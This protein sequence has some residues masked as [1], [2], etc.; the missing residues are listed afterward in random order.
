MLKKLNGIFAFAIYDG[1]RQAHLFLARDGIGVK[2]LYYAE[3]MSGFLF[4]SEIKALLV[5]NE[6]K[7]EID[8]TAIHYYLAYLWCPGQ[9]TALQA[10]KK[11]Q[12]GEAMIIRDGRIIKRWYYYDIPYHGNFSQ[13]S[14][15]E[16][17]AEL[18]THLV[19]AVNRQLVADVPVGAF[20]SGGLDSSA[21]VAMMRKLKANEE[22]NCFSIDF[23]E[24]MASEGNPKDLPY[25][26]TVAKHLN[27]NLH[28]LEMQA[29]MIEHLPYMI[30]HLDEPQA[31][32]APIH[33]FLIAEAARR[34]GTKV[35]LSGAEEMIFFL[36]TGAI[37]HCVWKIFGVLCLWRCAKKSLAMR[38]QCL[39][40]KL[41]IL[42]KNPVLDV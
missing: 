9:Q 28:V 34:N 30:Y 21:I 10:V 1:R 41:P 3:V 36:A 5:C 7:R 39:K 14:I 20:L 12:P 6:I 24:G 25:A 32:P 38:V 11:V 22:I 2:P 37:K 15:Q 31:D 17:C 29:N 35:L 23:A 19:Q 40:V 18:E 27:V 4:A 8:L 33:V 26:K 42:C 16:M 13:Q